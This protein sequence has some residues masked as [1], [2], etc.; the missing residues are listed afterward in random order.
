MRAELKKNDIRSSAREELRGFSVVDRREV[1]ECVSGGE[2]VV[3]VDGVCSH[4]A[5]GGPCI[6]LALS[7]YSHSCDKS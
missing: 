7:F 5:R 3:D 6:V 1:S 2:T 4:A